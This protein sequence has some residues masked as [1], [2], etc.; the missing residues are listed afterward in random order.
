MPSPSRH[1]LSVLQLIE[2]KFNHS[3]SSPSSSVP[4][5]WYLFFIF[6]FFIVYPQLSSICLVFFD[7][8]VTLIY[9]S[10]FCLQLSFTLSYSSLPVICLHLSSSLTTYVLVCLH[11]LLQCFTILIYH[12]LS[13]LFTN[14]PCLTCVHFS[15]FFFTSSLHVFFIFF[16]V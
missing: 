1:H 6:S 13:S 4:I 11:F 3:N 5:P 16:H 15:S 2:A 8:V 12:I 9:L 14:V 7:P 10:S